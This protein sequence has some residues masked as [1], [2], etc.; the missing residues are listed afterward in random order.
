MGRTVLRGENRILV[1]YL[2]QS[3]RLDNIYLTVPLNDSGKVLG[4][5]RP[6][7]QLRKAI[8]NTGHGL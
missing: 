3:L 8:Q 2:S 1:Q 4:S 7:S 5:Y 6:N